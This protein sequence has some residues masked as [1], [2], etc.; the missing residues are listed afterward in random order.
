[1]Q[2][3]QGGKFKWWGIVPALLALGLMAG[4]DFGYLPLSFLPSS[5]RNSAATLVFW[6][7]A[8]VIGLYLLHAIWLALRV[9]RAMQSPRHRNRIQFLLLTLTVAAIGFGLILSQNILL[10]EVGLLIHW[11]AS[12]LLVYLSITANLPDIRTSVKESLGFMI[13]VSFTMVIYLGTIYALEKALA[14]TSRSHLKTAF[15]AAVVF[16][17]LYPPL[18]K[19]LLV[20]VRRLL[21]RRRYD[22]RQII[23]E[24]VQAINN[25]LIMKDLIAVSLSFI[26]EELNIQHGA[27]FLTQRQDKSRYYFGIHPDSHQA[28]PKTFS[29]KKETLFAR[30]LAVE[31][32]SVSQYSL[33]I[34]PQFCNADPLCLQTLKQMK[35]EQYIPIKRNNDLI[36]ILAVGPFSSGESYA[37]RDIELLS[38]LANQTAIALENARLFDNVRQNLEE[39]TR[40]KTL[41]DNIFASIESGVITIDTQGQI[42]VLNQAAYRILNLPPTLQS[43][44]NVNEIFKYLQGTPLPALLRD[45]KNTRRSYRAYEISPKIVGRGQV[46]LTVDLSPILDSKKQFKGTA[47]VINDYT[48]TKQLQVVQNLFRKYLSPAVVDRLPRNPEELKLGGRRQ[49]VTVLFADIRGFS[50]YSENQSP[51]DLITVLNKYLSIAAEAILAYE[52]TLDKFMGDAV[53]AIFN[54]PLE[55]A[56]HPQRAVK[57]AAAMQRNIT[58]F[59]K[60]MG[61]YAAQLSFGVGIHV[62]E[63]V[64][65]NVGTQARMDYTAIGDAVNLA[66]RIQEN[67]PA[68]RILLSERAYICVKE[69]VHAIPHKNLSVKGRQAQEE[70]YELLNIL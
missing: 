6:L 66:K 33:D 3:D 68:G 50:T 37:L 54:A 35:I 39:I 63:A 44:G 58:E 29:L 48:E 27:Y 20:S 53:M 30:R 41:T 25:I 69:Y 8:G 64:I 19:A 60:V 4:M 62:G 1:M 40:I 57:A 49:E 14:S 36:A 11:L 70:T 15:V 10:Q 31:G 32:Q 47:I 55:Q 12:L 42:V 23:K 38:T 24:Y 34:D 28:L 16:T 52:G 45:V 5:I 67:T 26:R 59:N 22:A 13:I 18:R 17:L 43:G 56:D 61:G 7:G 2:V 51:E 46:D 21:F 9:Q 65:G